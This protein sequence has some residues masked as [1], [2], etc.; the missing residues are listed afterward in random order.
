MSTTLRAE[1]GSSPDGVGDWI[2]S[3]SNQS[4]WGDYEMDCWTDIEWQ[5]RPVLPFYGPMSECPAAVLDLEFDTDFGAP[6]RPVYVAWTTE[7]VITP[8]EY[9]GSTCV[10][11]IHRNPNPSAIEASA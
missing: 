6:S 5:G 2:C 3:I 9:D 10:T 11:W 8:T 1:F 7:Y 4:E